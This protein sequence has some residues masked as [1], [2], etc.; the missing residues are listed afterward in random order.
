MSTFIHT[1]TYTV[2][3][4]SEC[5]VAFG[6]TNQF[7]ATRRRDRKNFYCPN[8][9][10][11]WYPGKTAEQEAKELRARLE[12]ARKTQDHLRSEADHQ[13]AVARGYKGALT[14]VKKRVGNGVCPCCNRQFVD[15]AAHMATKHPDYADS[16][17]AG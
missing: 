8:G 13:A 9:H 4:C 5:S 15:V 3:H 7:I 10:S 17:E 11:Q 1:Q 12:A 14:K 16:P 6:L 2:L